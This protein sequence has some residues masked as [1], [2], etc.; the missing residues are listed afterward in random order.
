MKQLARIAGIVMLLIASVTRVSAVNFEE[1]NMTVQL[2]EEYYD[3]KAGIEAE[4]SKIMYYETMLNTTKEQL[5]EQITTN[6]ILYDGI[7]A[8]LSKELTIS[9]L[10]NSSTK[11]TFHLHS[12]SEQEINDLQEEL[13]Q[14]AQS[15]QMQV[16]KID[17]YQTNGLKW[18]TLTMKSYS[19][20]VYQYYTVVNGTGVTISLSCSGE[21]AKQEELKNVIDT[22][23]FSELKEKAPDFTN[24]IIIG[25][26]VVL[27]IIVIVLMIM[28]FSKKKDEN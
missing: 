6:H 10:E 22:V 7:N 17:V 25:V 8:N 1:L 27:V 15:K 12:L 20:T 14:E 18:I 11:R 5:K 24:Y 9:T 4:D 26:S 13:R 2:P 23:T 19:N 16:E 28:A 3:L 21:D